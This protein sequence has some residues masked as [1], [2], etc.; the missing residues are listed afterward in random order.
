MPVQGPQ[1]SEYLSCPVCKQEFEVR[2]YSFY[3]SAING[4]NKPGNNF[5]VAGNKE[6]SGVPGMRAHRVPDMPRLP[7]DAAVPLRQHPHRRLQ[8][9]CVA[10]QHRTPSA[11]R[12][13]GG[14]SQVIRG[15]R[16]NM[17]DTLDPQV[18]S[19]ANRTGTG[20]GGAI[21]S[22]AQVDPQSL[23]PTNFPPGALRSWLSS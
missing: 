13:W 14:A 16:P 12:E 5:C 2:K 8:P 1:W 15:F 9:R 4:Q 22:C 6:A 19:P 18:P 17:F 23:T 7:A 11:H 21:P 20:G 3:T 10:G